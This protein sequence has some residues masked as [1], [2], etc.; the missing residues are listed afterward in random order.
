[1][2]KEKRP[3]FMVLARTSSDR[4]YPHPVE[5]TLHPAG[6]DSI[7]GFSIGP[8]VVNAGGLVPLERVLDDSQTGLNRAFNKEFDAA[9]LQWVVPLL[10]RLH[11]GEDVK[12]EIVAAYKERHGSRPDWTP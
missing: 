8:H 7:L 12:E 9:E 3:N 2:A 4:P 5:V 6:K 1:M 11:K 10:V